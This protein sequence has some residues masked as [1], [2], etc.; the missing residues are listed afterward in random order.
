MSQVYSW[1]RPSGLY[2]VFVVVDLL[3]HWES[4]FSRSSRLTSESSS[5][6][7][8]VPVQTPVLSTEDTLQKRA[9]V[10]PMLQVIFFGKQ[11]QQIHAVW[12]SERN[13]GTKLSNFC[14][15]LAE[16][17]VIMCA[18]FLRFAWCGLILICLKSALQNNLSRLP[19]HLLE[20]ENVLGGITLGTKY[21]L[22]RIRKH[23]ANTF[24]AKMM[25]KIIIVLTKKHHCCR[26]IPTRLTVNH[27]MQWCAVVSFDIVWVH[28]DI[29]IYSAC[30]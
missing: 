6:C 24:V 16:R 30:L 7:V 28:R 13:L 25:S 29:Y 5:M 11:P 1:Y 19:E 23:D 20:V 4:Y 17:I 27:G 10:H 2:L 22:V 3:V 12:C 21:T 18:N 9:S 8:F 26:R 15:N 14:I